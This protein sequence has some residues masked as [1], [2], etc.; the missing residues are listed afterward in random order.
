MFDSAP[1]KKDNKLS[2]SNM[3]SLLQELKIMG[4]IGFH[5]NVIQLIGCYTSQ[6]GSHGKPFFSSRHIKM[7][8][9]LNGFKQIYSF[10]VSHTFLLN[11]VLMAI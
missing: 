7:G 11:T 4:Y 8:F 10:K 2:S 5:I 6:L 9:F 1:V 3:D